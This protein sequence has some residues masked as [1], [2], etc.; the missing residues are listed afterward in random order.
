MGEHER[1]LRYRLRLDIMLATILLIGQ[2]RL[3]TRERGAW[4][5]QGVIPECR[6]RRSTVLCEPAGTAFLL[7]NAVNPSTIRQGINGIYRGLA[8]RHSI[9]G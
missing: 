5:G 3:T 4:L 8:L 9:R 7:T 1:Q 6:A 2:I